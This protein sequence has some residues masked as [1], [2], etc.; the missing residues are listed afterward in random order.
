MSKLFLRVASEWPSALGQLR[1][2]DGITYAYVCACLSKTLSAGKAKRLFLEYKNDARLGILPWSL[3][4][5]GRSNLLVD[6]SEEVEDIENKQQ[7]EHYERM[8]FS[9]ETIRSLTLR[10]VNGP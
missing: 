9:S 7:K 8:G 4:K 6:L 2:C 10:G 3:G 5:L 1:K